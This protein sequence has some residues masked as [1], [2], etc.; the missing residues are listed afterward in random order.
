MNPGMLGGPD[1][2]GLWRTGWDAMR[3][4]DSNEKFV[5]LLGHETGVS[6]GDAACRCNPEGGGMLDRIKA[7]RLASQVVAGCSDGCGGAQRVLFNSQFAWEFGYVEYAIAAALQERGHAVGMIACAGLPDYCEQENSISRRPACT[8]CTQRLCRRLDAFGLPLLAMSEY[9][10]EADMLRARCEE[11]PTESLRDLSVSGVPVGRLAFLNLIQYYRGHPFDLV[12]E[13]EAVFRR[14]VCSAILVTLAADRM[15]DDFRPDVVCTANGKF[16]Q[17]APFYQIARARGIRCVT[18]EDMRIRTGAVVFACNGIAHE[19]PLEDVWQTAHN[20]PLTATQRS[21]LHEHFNHWASGASTPWKYYDD[22]ALVDGEAIR[23][24]LMLSSERRVVSLFP[25]LCWDST[26][27][28]FDSAFE[29]MY[30][31][32]EHTV[33]CAREMPQIDFVIRAHPGEFKL[34]P[35]FQSTTPVAEHLR[36]VCRPLPTNVRLLEG[37]SPISSYGLG[38]VSDIVMTYTS[39]LGVEFAMRGIR[40]WCVARAPYGRKGFTLD[41]TCPADIERWLNEERFDNRL[42]PEQVALAEQFA[43]IFRFRRVLA[44]PH[45]NDTGDFRP[46]D[47]AFFQRGGHRA[48]DNLCEDILTGGVFLDLGSRRTAKE[49]VACP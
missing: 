20:P 6:L 16:L 1:E 15:I 47:W 3:A 21:D 29:S 27:V 18:W 19:L 36:R 32:L 11:V 38:E 10:D 43:H 48:I 46:P 26:S 41:A 35:Q 17:W 39:T 30:A 45:L 44:F 7:M 23:R 2:S 31:W 49:C 5:R 37:D 42:S 40:P 12:G 24:Q 28:G 8:E 34:P 25:N 4:T 22:S 33:H 14:C 13:K 9:L